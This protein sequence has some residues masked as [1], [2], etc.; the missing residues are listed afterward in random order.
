MVETSIFYSSLNNLRLN[1]LYILLEPEISME[2][3]EMC[4]GGPS[5]LM[6]VLSSP[7]HTLALC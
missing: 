7:L 1:G 2:A 3:L 6:T 5:V 4:N